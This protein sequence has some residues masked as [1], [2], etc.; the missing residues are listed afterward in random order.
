MVNVPT[1]AEVKARYPEF[2]PVDDDVVTLTITD[3][4]R[5]VDDGWNLEDQ[6][7]GIINLTAHMLSLEGYPSRVSAPGGWNGQTAGR[8]MLS[9][10]VGDVQTT[11]AQRGSTGSVS[12]EFFSELKMTI[13]GRRFY[14][15]M[16]LNAP[17]IGVA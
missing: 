2:E 9:R 5:Y 11:Y 6:K 17:T 10:R 12:S 4:S 8:E 7:P 14:N 1:A 15:L 16:R 13:Y 3:A